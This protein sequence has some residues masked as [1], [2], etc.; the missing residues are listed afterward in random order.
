MQ[1]PKEDKRTNNDNITQ[2]AKDRA[3]RTSLKTGVNSG[4]TKGL[5]VPAPHVTPA[6]VSKL[7]HV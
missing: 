2:K 4:A 1:L 3:M 5:A 6:V 7:L